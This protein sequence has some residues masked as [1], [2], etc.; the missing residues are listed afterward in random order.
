MCSEL[1][2]KLYIM[3]QNV[4]IPEQLSYVKKEKLLHAFRKTCVFNLDLKQ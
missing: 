2:I 1:F 3:L 4:S